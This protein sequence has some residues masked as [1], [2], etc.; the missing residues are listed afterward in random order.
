[1]RK[2]ICIGIAI[3]SLMSGYGLSNKAAEANDI[4]AKTFLE[5]SLEYVICC[6]R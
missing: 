2:T 3:S 4:G 1:M 5:N 6:Y